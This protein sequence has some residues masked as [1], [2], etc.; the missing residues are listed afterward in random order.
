ML[1]GQDGYQ[2]YK[3]PFIVI[4]GHIAVVEGHEKK[5]EKALSRLSSW[6]DPAADFS[7]DLEA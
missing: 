5:S 7:V 3:R 6:V 4:L 2:M 1:L